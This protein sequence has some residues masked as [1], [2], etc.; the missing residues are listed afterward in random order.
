MPFHHSVLGKLAVRVFVVKEVSS[1]HVG[2]VS[3]GHRCEA[4]FL[5][6][7]RKISLSPRLVRIPKDMVA[8]L[9]EGI[10][11]R[12]WGEHRRGR[13]GEN[14]GRGPSCRF[15]GEGRRGRRTHPE[16]QSCQKP[17]QKNAFGRQRAFWGPRAVHGRWGHGAEGERGTV[18]IHGRT[19]SSSG[20]SD[21]SMRETVD[22]WVG[23]GK[24]TRG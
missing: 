14:L 2:A 3:T 9:T 17:E 1:E 18:R 13:S 11:R 23:D 16:D 22:G 21:C 7:R 8:N 24:G 4:W 20:W 5:F 15:R 19:K 12:T 6:E 10:E